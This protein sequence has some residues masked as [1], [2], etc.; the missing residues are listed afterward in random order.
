MRIISNNFC[1]VVAVRSLL[2]CFRRRYVSLCIIIIPQKQ[3]IKEVRLWL[4]FLTDKIVVYD[5]GLVVLPN[6]SIFFCWKF[7]LARIKKNS[8]NLCLTLILYIADTFHASD[9]L[10]T[11]L[12]QTFL[13]ILVFLKWLSSCISLTS[14]RIMTRSRQFSELL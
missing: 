13:I 9:L 12:N 1:L 2:H 10:N 6:K 14:W 8:K 3:H 5:D 4:C 7:N 11:G